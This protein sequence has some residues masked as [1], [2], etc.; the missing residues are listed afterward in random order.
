MSLLH[1]LA[2]RLSPENRL[3]R[4]PARSVF[5][6]A[7]AVGCIA[8]PSAAQ[9]AAPTAHASQFRP[10]LSS[11]HF[12]LCTVK[13]SKVWSTV[14]IA[15]TPPPPTVETYSN[16]IPGIKPR[17]TVTGTECSYSAPQGSTVVNLSYDV[18]SR[19][20]TVT[21]LEAAM[22]SELAKGKLAIMGVSLSC[23]KYSPLPNAVSCKETI[24]PKLPP[25]ITLPKGLP[26][27]VTL[28]PSLFAKK[29]YTSVGTLNGS[30]AHSAEINNGTTDLSTL[31]KLI[32]LAMAS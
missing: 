31:A 12:T 19:S 23:Q 21:T 3:R 8:I 14:G 5:A 22:K 11:V 13:A 18:Y 10:S 24:T 16:V 15:G 9:A 1:P 29:V 28:P 17:L 32:G 27:G 7:A 2:L 26:K 25:G 20:V 30:K 6:V 4:H